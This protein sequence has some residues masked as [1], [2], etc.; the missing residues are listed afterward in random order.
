MSII[1]ELVYE[2]IGL[3]N[4]LI[5]LGVS[6]EWLLIKKEE[7]LRDYLPLNLHCDE[8]A[9]EMFYTIYSMDLRIMEGE[10]LD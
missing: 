2:S 7:C 4:K 3:E 5:K 6:K 10:R 9:I 8:L 1:N